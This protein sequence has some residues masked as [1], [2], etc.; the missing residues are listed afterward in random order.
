MTGSLVNLQRP[1]RVLPPFSMANLYNG[2]MDRLRDVGVHKLIQYQG[3]ASQLLNAHG[4]DKQGRPSPLHRATSRRASSSI[5]T[6]LSLAAAKLA[7]DIL[8]PTGAFKTQL[9]V[10][11]R[12]GTVTLTPDVQE[13]LDHLIARLTAGS[14]RA[15]L[16][17]MGCTIGKRT[18]PRFEP[19]CRKPAYG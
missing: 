11:R 4:I 12:S 6:A 9:K 17:T 7:K 18:L 1:G 15:A 13:R 2:L 5:N 16:Q 14:G 19:I 10:L 3:M 8:A